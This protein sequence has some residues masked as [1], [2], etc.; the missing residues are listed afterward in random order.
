MLEIALLHPGLYAY[1]Q[2]NGIEVSML[3]KDGSLS[4]LVDN[5][6]RVHCQ[7]LPKNNLIFEARLLRLPSEFSAC[8][9]LL[10]QCLAIAAARLTK[11]REWPTIDQHAQQLLLQYYL[12]AHAHTQQHFENAL[13]DFI[14][15]LMAWREVLVA[16]RPAPT[17]FLDS[18]R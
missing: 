7:S 15:A 11:A 16:R 10:D 13:A 1:M 4:L 18:T 12:A 9:A 14:N 2:A 8:E 3:N 5:R 6:Y 17:L